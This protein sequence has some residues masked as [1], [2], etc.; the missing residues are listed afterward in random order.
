MILLLL[1]INV[2]LYKDLIFFTVW[3]IHIHDAISLYI[4]NHQTIQPT[5]YLLWWDNFKNLDFVDIT[6]KVGCSEFII[7]FTNISNVCQHSTFCDSLVVLIGAWVIHWRWRMFTHKLHHSSS[8][9]LT[10]LLWFFQCMPNHI[11]V[12]MIDV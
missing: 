8:L 5:F 2:L 6:H 12:V 11:K 7:P 9:K 1:Y 10:N 3:K 4:P